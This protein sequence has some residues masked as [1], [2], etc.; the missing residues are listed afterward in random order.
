MD[1]ENWSDVPPVWDIRQYSC[2]WSR[3]DVTVTCN[4]VIGYG[5]IIC[6]TIK[7]RT[8]RLNDYIIIQ[9]YFVL[10]NNTTATDL[11]LLFT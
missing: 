7:Y 4:C 10:S 9:K 11:T 2:A 5:D 8:E 3:Y 6:R 1:K